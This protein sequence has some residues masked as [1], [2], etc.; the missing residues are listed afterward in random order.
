M[1]VSLGTSSGSLQ[2]S[3]EKHGHPEATRVDVCWEE[4]GKEGEME[5][6]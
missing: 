2:L 4:G 5:G 3:L 1:P 6:A